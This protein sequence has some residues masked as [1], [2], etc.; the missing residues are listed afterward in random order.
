MRARD[1]VQHGGVEFARDLGLL[2]DQQALDR[3][4]SPMR[5]AED[6]SARPAAA[7]SGVPRELDAAGLAA[8]AGRHLRLDHAGADL[9][10]HA[11]A[12]SLRRRADGSPRG[13]GM[14][15]RRQDQRL[16]GVFLAGSSSQH[17]PP[18]SAVIPYFF[19]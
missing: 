14:P 1:V 9:A 6:L 15:A 16:G 13:T 7:S 4:S 3:C 2:L 5:H 17:R 19:Q 11:C 18:V 12:A 8:L 10:R